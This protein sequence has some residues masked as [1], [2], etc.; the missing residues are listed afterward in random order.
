MSA[1]W[2]LERYHQAFTLAAHAHADQRIADSEVPYIVHVA[3]VA[4]ET[5]AALLAAPPGLD[6]DLAL[7][8]AL[9]HDTIED[10]KVTYAE[11]AAAFGERVA[12]GVLALT[13]N[14]ELPKADQMADSLQ[15][16]LA[17]GPEVRLVKMADRV[18]LRRVWPPKSRRTRSI[19]G[20]QGGIVRKIAKPTC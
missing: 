6:W 1:P 10:T 18:P 3:E 9:L 13:K 19:L 7:A 15:R 17:Q 4:N 12:Q 16:I 11:V 20:K 14:F 8:C 5:L 2:S